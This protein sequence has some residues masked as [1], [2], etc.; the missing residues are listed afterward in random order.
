MADLTLDEIAE[1]VAADMEAHASYVPH[2]VDHVA[3]DLARGYAVQDAV[4]ARLSRG[5]RGAVAGY[6]LAA[7]SAA[8]M[9]LFGLREPVTG[10]LFRGQVHESPA[11][12]DAAAWHEPAF[13][14]EIAAIIGADLGT[15]ADAA[16]ATRAVRLFV[17]AFELLD[18]RA[19]A[20]PPPDMAE[21]VGQNITNEGVVLGGPGVPPA[22]LGNLS[23]LTARL[24]V[25]GIET[26]DVTGKAPQ[27]PLEAVA[28]LA[29]HLAG[30]GLVLKA[31]MVVLCG[32]H[33][34]IQYPLRGARVVLE[35]GALG[36]AE[37][38]L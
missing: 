26:A 15:D 13:E 5:P 25:D 8:L 22:D 38:T 36:R 9:E 17:P 33:T 11:R 24:T 4:T 37:T 35:M 21:S 2:G 30:R 10:R 28:W 6:K 7:N 23:A 29:R 27:D 14:P 16:E 1:A 32:T 20:K 34:P 19:I 31:G 3:R 18:M 12:I